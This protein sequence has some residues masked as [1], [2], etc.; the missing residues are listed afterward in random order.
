MADSDRM[1][2]RQIVVIP[3][4]ALREPPQVGPDVL[5]GY[6]FNDCEIR[7]PA[8]LAIAG[9]TSFVECTFDTTDVLIPLPEDRGYHGL[10]E[11]R[12]C[13]FER[14]TFQRIG[15]AG[16]QELIDRFLA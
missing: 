6:I 11:A 7:G 9:N 13:T 16:S 10:V 12:N 5:E 8:V 15:I 14:C 2:R 4:I 1:F 3:E